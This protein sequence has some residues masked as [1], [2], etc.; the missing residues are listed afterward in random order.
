MPVEP[1]PKEDELT[2]R[3]TVPRDPRQA[4]LRD[5]GRSVRPGRRAA[6]R[7]RRLPVVYVS[8]SG[9][10]TA[11]DGLHRRRAD[12]LQGDARQRAPRRRRDL[13]ADAL[14]HRH[15]LRQRDNVKRTIREY[16][17]IG[18]AGVHIEDQTFP[19]RCGQTAGR[20][21]RRRRRDVR[22][23]LRGQGGP[24]G[25]GLR[26]RSCAPTRAR[27]R[28]WTA[29]IERSRAYL[30]AGCDAIF[31]EALLAE[32]GVPAHARGAARRAARDR[33]PRVGPEPDDDDRRA[34]GVGLRP[35]HLRDLGD[36]RRARR[37]ARV[38][39]RPACRGDAAQ[40]DRPDDD[41]APRSTSCSGCPQ[42]RED[43]ERLLELGRSVTVPR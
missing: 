11:V 35:R 20:A 36:A 37:G 30:A 24:A 17:Q 2:A 4:G 25:R 5:G 10:S 26:A 33:R 27:S 12:Q 21:P 19:K 8:G 34:R 42:I 40:L 32:R 43:E 15:G 23:D 3:S 22:E 31:P 18:A 6:R 38:P 28:A 13:A 41:A 14:R 7:A 9:S 1:E 39:R 29:S 16:E